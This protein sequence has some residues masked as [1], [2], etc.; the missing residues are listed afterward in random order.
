MAPS[1]GQ[2]CNH[3]KSCQVMVRFRTDPSGAIWWPTLKL[4]G[5][6]RSW[7]QFL[8]PLCL[9]QCF[10]HKHN[11]WAQ[12]FRAEKD[13]GWWWQFAIL[14]HRCY[15]NLDI[16]SRDCASPLWWVSSPWRPSSCPPSSSTL[17][18]SQVEI[19]QKRPKLRVMR[20]DVGVAKLPSH[21]KLDFFGFFTVYW[22]NQLMFYSTSWW[23]YQ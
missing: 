17:N 12:F 23:K 19:E 15:Y 4:M 2:I 20:L 13:D 10:L 7:S 1:S 18:E 8:G 5:N 3:L 22:N 21:Q 6:S 14:W 9:W 11:F 16:T